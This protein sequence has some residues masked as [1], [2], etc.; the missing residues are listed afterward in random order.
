MRTRPPSTCTHARRR[1]PGLGEGRVPAQ[2]A[3]RA[4]L[5]ERGAVRA[6]EEAAHDAVPGAAGRAQRLEA[7]LAR[8]DRDLHPGAGEIVGGDVQRRRRAVGE[9][10]PQLLDLP[11]A[12]RRRCL[13]RA[14]PAGERDEPGMRVGR[15]E[16]MNAG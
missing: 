6:G 2:D 13:G 15:G 16:C 9:G 14:P 5:A 1:R 3:P 11:R 7:L 4:D 12:R 10:D 8:G